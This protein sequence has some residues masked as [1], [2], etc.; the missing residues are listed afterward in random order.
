MCFARRC[1]TL[2]TPLPKCVYSTKSKSSMNWSNTSTACIVADGASAA[3]SAK[4]WKNNNQQRL[5]G[6]VLQYDVK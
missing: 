6:V 2:C 4:S 5:V 3:A 1:T